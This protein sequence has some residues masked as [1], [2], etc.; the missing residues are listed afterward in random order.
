M[1]PAKLARLSLAISLAASLILAAC[2]GSDDDKATEELITANVSCKDLGVEAP[3]RIKSAGKFIVA[4]DLTYA[5]M[6]F[7]RPGTTEAIGADIDLARCIADAWG[8]TL[9]VQNTSFDAIIPAL[10]SRKVDV[11]MSSMSVTDE[12]KQQ[13]DF[14]E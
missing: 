1:T 4:S 11:I 3:A 12:R 13:V 2:G 7:V 14:V 8:V 5:P 10:T 6:E 9:E